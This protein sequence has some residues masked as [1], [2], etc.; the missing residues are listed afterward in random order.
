MLITRLNLACPDSGVCCI[1]WG[2]EQMTRGFVP[3]GFILSL[4]I[5]C[6]DLFKMKIK[7]TFRDK[8]DPRPHVKLKGRTYLVGPLFF[9]FY[10]QKRISK[11]VN[12]TEIFVAV[13]LINR[14][15]TGRTEENHATDFFLFFL[16][17]FRCYNF[18]VRKFWP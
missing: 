2:N 18:K 10:V 5:M 17:F 14:Y 13:T 4:E 3:C 1:L 11:S 6:R 16:F 12:M 15:V 9:L 7:N 8:M